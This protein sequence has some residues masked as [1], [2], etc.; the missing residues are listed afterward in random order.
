MLREL[1]D[2]C[3]KDGLKLGV[4]LSPWDRNH[5]AYGTPAYNDVFVAMLTE[6]LTQYGPIFEVWFDGAN[7]EGPN[8]KRQVYDWPRFVDTVRRFQ[9]NAVIFSDAGPDVRWI[10]NEEGYADSTHWAMLRRDEFQPGTPRYKELTQGHSD[11]THWLPGECDVSIRPGW[12]YRASEDEKVK[13]VAKLVDIYYGSV[14]QGA[15]LLLNVPPD[16]SGRIHSIDAARLLA[17]RKVLR[18]TFRRDLARSSR[19]LEG[20]EVALRAIDGKTNTYWEGSE[21][22]SSLA[23]Q[24]PNP[25]RFD[26]VMLQEAI[27]FGQQVDEFLVEAR[28][29]GAWREVAEGTTI[30]AKR[31]LRLPDVEA[32]AL[33][34][35]IR[36]SFGSPKLSTLG[37]FHAPSTLEADGQELPSR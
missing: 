16:A 30:G 31:I 33:R 2:A 22:R 4:Y 13:S 25:V 10:G 9:P 32:D 35:T 17:W 36:K 7:G 37:V 26:R 1:A 11:G 14:G 6:V 15:S 23:I 34:V 27:R 29:D 8:G 3:R 24:W 19:V 18:Q 28:I 20:G 21:P 5:P 12:F